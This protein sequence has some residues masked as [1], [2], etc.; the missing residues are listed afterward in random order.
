MN[1]A[2]IDDAFALVVRFTVKPGRE[3]DFDALTAATVAD[4]HRDEPGTL[5]YVTHEVADRPGERIFYELY[6]DRAA[7]DAHEAQP[8]VRHFLAARAELLDGTEVDFLTSMVHAG[9]V[10]AR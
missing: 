10:S 7:F 1:L 8:H 2:T 3:A 5:L 6:R 9:D 4:V